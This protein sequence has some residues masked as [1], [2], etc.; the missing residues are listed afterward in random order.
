MGVNASR[1]R[2]VREDSLRN[3]QRL[4]DAALELFDTRGIEVPLREICERAD[5]SQAGLFRHFVN[6]DQLII[7]VYDRAAR[8]LSERV[9]AALVNVREGSA[10]ERL[11]TLLNTIFEAMVEH[12][13]YGQLAGHGVHLYPDRVT[14]PILVKEL[15]SLTNDAQAEG[16]LAS[17]I[18]EIDLVN[19]AVLTSGISLHSTSTRAASRVITILRRGLS[20]QAETIAAMTEPPPP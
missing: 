18:T 11:D 6:R 3:H 8:I 20:P 13:S 14:D 4:L 12:P 17:D 1:Q 5:V 16:V 15:A 7:E 2:A 19:T 10:E 9:I